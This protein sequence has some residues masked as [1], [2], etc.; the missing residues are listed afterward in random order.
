MA[1]YSDEFRA[2]A[3]LM[4]EAAGWPERKGALT[5]VARTL[6]I[7]HQTLS[8]WARRV[9]NPPPQNML[10]KK[11]FDL[12]QAIREELQAILNELPN[13]RPDAD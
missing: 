5:S 13:A 3:V 9:Q 4:L 6:G 2:Q 11:A 7:K 8:N 10:P 1:R 12:I